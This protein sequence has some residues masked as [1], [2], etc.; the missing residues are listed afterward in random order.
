MAPRS[1]AV[2]PQGHASDDPDWCD[3]CGLALAPVRPPAPPAPAPPPPGDCVACGAELEGWF[4]ETCGHDSRAPAAPT[5]QV[6]HSAPALAWWAVVRV[7]RA[8]FDEVRRQNGRGD[9]LE[10]PRY[11]PERR[12]ALADAQV[13]IGRRS[14][15]RGTAPDLDLGSLDPGVSAAH[16]VLV[17][18][19]DGGWEIVD[20]GSTN[21]TTLAVSDGPIPRHRPVPVADGTVIHLGAWTTITLT[22]APASQSR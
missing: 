2:C 4:C 11:A 13:T 1:T 12:F 14:A 17:A 3:V 6:A 8:W 9:T 15:S 21:G 16:A 20:V 19:P 18:R 5:E 22:A 10:F 7:D